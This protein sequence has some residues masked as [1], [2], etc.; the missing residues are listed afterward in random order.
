MNDLRRIPDADT[1]PDLRR[2]TPIGAARAFGIYG[3]SILL[4]L[5][6][7]LLHRRRR[8]RDQVVSDYDQGVWT[9]QLDA[10][11][12]DRVD[13]L[14]DYLGKAWLNGDV[15]SLVDGRLWR[16]PIA[17]YY[18]LKRARILGILMRFAGDT[19][20]LVEL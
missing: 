11:N 17:D 1:L 2:A 15:T 6:H 8:G 19:A 20:E 5:G 10:R 3:W 4:D 12:W 7:R 14:D 9:Q 13:T 18:R 16:M